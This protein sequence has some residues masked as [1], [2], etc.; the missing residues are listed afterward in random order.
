[1][2]AAEEAQRDVPAELADE[3]VDQRLRRTAAG[4]VR[5]ER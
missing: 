2:D 1:V 3:L 4:E 5:V